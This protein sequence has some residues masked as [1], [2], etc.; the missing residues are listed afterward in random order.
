MGR[1]RWLHKSF[2]QFII[3]NL[4][5]NFEII[6]EKMHK[7]AFHLS[8][9]LPQLNQDHTQQFGTLWNVW[10]NVYI[11]FFLSKFV[12]KIKIDYRIRYKLNN[13][14]NTCIEIYMHLQYN[15]N[16]GCNTIRKF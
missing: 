1:Y 8:T 16:K 3:N 9:A 14:D 15:N 13:Q 5:L 10:I 2:V 6:N 7:P 12:I 11:V 4:S